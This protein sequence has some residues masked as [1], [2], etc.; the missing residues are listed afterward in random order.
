[1]G[2]G[3]RI[4]LGGLGQGITRAADDFGRAQADDQRRR[5]DEMMEQL[6]GRRANQA[7]ER[8]TTDQILRVQT[9][10]GQVGDLDPRYYNP[11]GTVK[12]TNGNG[13][14]G[15]VVGASTASTQESEHQ[16]LRKAGRMSGKDVWLPAD[17]ITPQQRAQDKDRDALREQ[18]AG[19]AEANRLERE[20]AARERAETARQIALLRAGGADGSGITPYQKA[21]GKRQDRK[22]ATQNF[23]SARVNARSE[24]NSLP[25]PKPRDYAGF[26]SG[27]GRFSGSAP[28]SAGFRKDT[29]AYHQQR[30]DLR[31]QE[32][33]SGYSADSTV[34]A[35][36]HERNN[37]GL[38][39]ADD[40]P[41]FI[42][43]QAQRRISTA[44]V[45]YQQ[46]VRESH[47]DPDAQR[48]A[49]Q[50]YAQIKQETLQGV[51]RELWPRLKY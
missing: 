16:P 30:N 11:D 28:D 27:M 20:R 44:R 37:P 41:E 2:I 7:D 47:S 15:A 39:N 25:K 49:A 36:Q 40:D 17:G 5:H 18:N 32:G 10:G 6:A 23:R 29:E 1:M 3:F 43:Q 26:D 33:M 31:F 9:Q 8:E 51:P 42:V 4:A 13:S 22:E 38:E 19:I 34:A 48:E 46:A 50:H 14:V 24:M 35:G 45:L 21:T 12:S